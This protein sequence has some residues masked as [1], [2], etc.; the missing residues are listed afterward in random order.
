MFLET[1]KL[2]SYPS[3]F[4]SSVENNLKPTVVSHLAME[5]IGRT[6]WFG[7]VMANKSNSRGEPIASRS[8]TYT[9]KHTQSLYELFYSKNGS[10]IQHFGLC[11]RVFG[12]L[13]HSASEIPDDWPPADNT[14]NL[15]HKLVQTPGTFH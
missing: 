3:W 4:M 6:S 1:S 10:L 15:S 11:D 8:W 7:E 12:L 9:H 13:Y 14:V 2:S 5:R